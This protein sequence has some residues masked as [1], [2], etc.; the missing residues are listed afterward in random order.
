VVRGFALVFWRLSF[1]CWVA[2]FGVVGV[3]SARGS[4]DS[5]VSKDT[6]RDDASSST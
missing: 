3:I 6:L 2:V 1:F 5:R 4:N